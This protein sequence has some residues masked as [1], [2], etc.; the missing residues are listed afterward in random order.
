M[1]IDKSIY[2]ETDFDKV[3]AL[4]LREDYDI[5]WLQL[6]LFENLQY[7]NL[8]GHDLGELPEEILQLNKLETLLLNGNGMNYDLEDFSKSH[9][10]NLEC[11]HLDI[12]TSDGREIPDFCSPIPQV[13]ELGLFINPEHIEYKPW[14][15][16]NFAHPREEYDLPHD[17][18]SLGQLEKLV[19]AFNAA[20]SNYEVLYF[21]DVFQKIYSLKNLQKLTAISIRNNAAAEYNID[22]LRYSKAINNYLP[23]VTVS[24]F[25]EEGNKLK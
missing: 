7:L 9:F 1:K 15:S 5:D 20:L 24:V 22:I 2:A 23:N 14:S 25:D 8:S 18:G 3:Y 6:S 11:L 19:V 17:L 21:Y 10:P 4:D 13:K 16:G 12:D